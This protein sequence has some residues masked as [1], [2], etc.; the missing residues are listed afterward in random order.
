PDLTRDGVE[1][2]QV[3]LKA[4]GGRARAAV[5]APFLGVHGSIDLDVVAAGQGRHVEE[6]RLRTVA[7]WP[8]VIAAQDGRAYL[9]DR[10]VRSGVNGYSRIGLDVLG[11]VVVERLAGL[12]V[13]SLRPVD[14]VHVGLDAENLAVVAVH[15]IDET[16]T[17]RMGDEFAKLAGHLGVDQNV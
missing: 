16:V 6:P 10:I 12:L 8:V 7:G 5:P 9:P 15:R 11:R 3:A 13:D 1:C 14:I 17:G 2:S 4:I